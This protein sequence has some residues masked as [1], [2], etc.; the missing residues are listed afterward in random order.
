ML[1]PRH[2]M[3]RGKAFYTNPPT[4]GVQ[5]LAECGLLG[6]EYT[7]HVGC[8]PIERVVVFSNGGR[9]QALVAPKHCKGV[10][11]RGDAGLVML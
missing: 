3:P 7:S 10:S 8:G 2:R 1:A 6:W 11:V 5:G 4:S 9:R